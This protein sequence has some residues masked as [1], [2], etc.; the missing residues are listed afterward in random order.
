MNTPLIIG[1]AL[2]GIVLSHAASYVLFP[3]IAIMVLLALFVPSEPKAA[4][5]SR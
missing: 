2:A 1:A 5:P 3:A 4:A